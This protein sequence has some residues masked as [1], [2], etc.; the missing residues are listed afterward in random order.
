[1]TN[2]WGK[3]STNFAHNFETNFDKISY[4]SRTSSFLEKYAVRSDRHFLAG[5]SEP[6]MGAHQTLRPSTLR[7]FGRFF[8]IA[9]YFY[10]KSWFWTVLVKKRHLPS[11]SRCPKAW[12]ERFTASQGAR[13]VHTCSRNTRSFAWVAFRSDVNFAYFPNTCAKVTVCT[14]VLIEI[15]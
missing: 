5:L 2:F 7:C 13:Q 12:F 8:G 1:M 3:S 4:V 6:S 10:G 9:K 15:I 11:Q 14:Q